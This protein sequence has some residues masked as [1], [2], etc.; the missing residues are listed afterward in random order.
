M[1]AESQQV[2][3]LWTV[4]SWATAI[5]TVPLILLVNTLLRLESSAT[6]GTFGF[7]CGFRLFI[8]ATA[9]FVIGALL[10]IRALIVPEKRPWL[11]WIAFLLNATPAAAGV[12]VL[13]LLTG[14]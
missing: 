11:G 8:A 12:F 10:A 1:N 7:E 9:L 13:M 3:S 6:C 2:G 5:A 4:L 14:R